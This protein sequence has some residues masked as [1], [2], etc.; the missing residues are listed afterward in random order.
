[1][2]IC[3][4]HTY[5]LYVQHSILLNLYKAHHSVKDLVSIIIIRDKEED[6]LRYYADISELIAAVIV[7]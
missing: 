1:M 5:T 6:V 4:S 7:M 2:M 3:P